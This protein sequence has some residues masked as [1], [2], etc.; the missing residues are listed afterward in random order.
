VASRGFTKR[1]AAIGVLVFW[2][3]A[4]GGAIYA[5]SHSDWLMLTWTSCCIAAVP[6][7]LAAFKVRTKCGVITARGRRCPN[8][9]T[10]VLFGCGS[11]KDHT[12]AKLLSRFGLDR[13]HRPA[14]SDGSNRS[15]NTA[16]GAPTPNQAAGAFNELPSEAAKVQIE[17]SRVDT[18]LFWLTFCSTIAGVTSASIDFTGLFK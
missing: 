6:L 16:Q 18:L 1:N 17:R 9:S 8:P 3:S 5:A 14:R 10:G 11:A 2:V 7:W 15:N 12:W 13:R 4:I